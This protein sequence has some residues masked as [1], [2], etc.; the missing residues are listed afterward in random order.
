VELLLQNGARLDLVD[1]YGQTPLARAVE[2]GSVPVLRI[3][4]NRGAKM[5]YKYS[6]VSECNYI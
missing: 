2:E 4:L 6:F 3:L 1:E 5:D